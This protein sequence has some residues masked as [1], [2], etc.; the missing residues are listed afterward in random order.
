MTHSKGMELQ[1]MAVVRTFIALCLAAALSGC[2]SQVGASGGVTSTF[3]AAS[4]LTNLTR[5]DHR[6]ATVAFRLSAANVDLC[7]TVRQTAGWALHAAQQYSLE[8]RPLPA[9]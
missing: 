2:G 7:P 3:D 8:L 9:G 5:L 4:R 6:V 1:S